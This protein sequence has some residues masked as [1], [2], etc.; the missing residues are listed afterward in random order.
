MDGLQMLAALR[1][2]HPKLPVIM[3]ST[4]TERG[5]TVTL[6]ALSLGASDY[7]FKPSYVGSADAALTQLRE[8][9][10]PKIKK[11]C[12]PKQ[13]EMTPGLPKAR[14]FADPDAPSRVEILTIGV[15]TGGPN[16]LA[17]LLPGLVKNFPVPI[18]V[19]QHMP[20]L[21]T[22]LLAER[23]SAVSGL[24]AREGVS[25]ALLQTRRNLRG[26]RRFPHGSGEEPRKARGSDC[27]KG[28]Q[29]IPAARRWMFF[30]A[31]WRECFGPG[32]IAVVLTGM[33]QDWTARLRKYK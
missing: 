13:A 12:R 14:A 22:R 15:S 4:L 11:L 3:F 8:E 1:K 7:V 5:A 30:S 24:S 9:L 33:G 17:V 10:I 18:V 16:A 28:P 6:D 31:P 23:L 20:P 27:M 29:R 21:F 25:G 19:V 26:P 2:T 32:A